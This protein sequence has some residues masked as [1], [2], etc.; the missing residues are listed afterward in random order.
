MSRRCAC[1]TCYTRRRENTI[2]AL[3]AAV[4]MLAMTLAAVAL[5]WMPW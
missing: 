1:F 3:G 4:G 2:A 5:L